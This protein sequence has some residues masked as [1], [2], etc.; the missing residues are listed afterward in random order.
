MDLPKIQIQYLKTIYRITVE[1]GR[2]AKLQDLAK[3]MEV[4]EPS[5][6][7]ILKKLQDKGLITKVS[8]GRYT[9]TKKGVAITEAIIHNHRVLENFLAETLGLDPDM[10]CREAD[11]IDSAISNELARKICEKLGRPEQ[12]I[13]GRCI[14][15]FD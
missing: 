1:G 5:A 8:W 4:K 14:K 6:S 13:H 11:R 7:D 15:H 3:E 2:D 10:A 9:L 12:C